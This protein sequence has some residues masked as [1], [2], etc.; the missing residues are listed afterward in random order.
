LAPVPLDGIGIAGCGKQA[1]A[2]GEPLQVPLN[3]FG[4]VNA[5]A[6]VVAVGRLARL[7]LP[8]AKAVRVRNALLLRRGH[9]EDFTWT[10][11]A[12]PPTFR[13]ETSSAPAAIRD[14]VPSL[15]RESGDDWQR[16]LALVGMLVRHAQYDDAIQADLVTTY[17]GIVAGH[18]YCVDFVRVY[19][20]A[21]QSAGIFCRQ[22]AF[23]FDGFGGDG[24]TFVEVYIPQRAAWAFLD[25]HNNVFAVIAGSQIPADALSLRLALVNSPSSVEFRRAAPGRLGFPNTGKL[26]EYYQRGAYQ[27]YLWWGNDMVQ[28]EQAGLIRMVSRFSGRLAHRLVSVLGCTPPLVVLRTPENDHD[29][30]RMER[31]RHR[32][33][34]SVILCA[35]FIAALSLQVGWQWFERHHA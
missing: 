20:A 21:A 18:G 16:A 14:A 11:A 33:L 30:A 13:I 8:S 12:V 32:V 17:R 25:V 3:W 2:Q 24:H 5:S 1:Q 15:G 28:R 26:L 7:I 23:S 4:I 6:L 22:W 19:M 27:W 9:V 34:L 10:P 35:V 31:L 29:I